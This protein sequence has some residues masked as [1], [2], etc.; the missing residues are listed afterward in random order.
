[1]HSQLVATMRHF[2][3]A[4]LA[5]GVPITL[6][7]PHTLLLGEIGGQ[8]VGFSSG[9]SART[10]SPA[11]G[12]CHNT[13]GLVNSLARHGLQR[14]HLDTDTTRVLVHDGEVIA[15]RGA[16]DEQGALDPERVSYAERAVAAIPGLYSAT[17]TMGHQPNG[18]I[19]VRRIRQTINIMPFGDQAPALART[20]V[21]SE[22]AREGVEFGREAP[23]VAVVVTLNDV[24]AEAIAEALPSAC[25]E[26][27][28]ACGEL[29]SDD[30]DVQVELRGAPGDI[31]HVMTAV[32][33]PGLLAYPPTAATLTPA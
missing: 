20:I 12:L 9:S 11:R 23:D 22:C 26:R 18:D 6:L 15:A 28:V 32:M 25:G 2:Q 7:G 17:V 31:A 4:A 29:A 19:A 3:G 21:G 8:Q 30:G 33:H 24:P 10:T 27:S 1:M 14:T 16:G 5:G 13:R